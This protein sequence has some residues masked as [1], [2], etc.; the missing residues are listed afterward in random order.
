MPGQRSPFKVMAR[1]NPQMKKASIRFKQ[2]MG[3]DL[4]TYSE[5]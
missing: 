1:Y 3:G 5:K 4:S 2:L